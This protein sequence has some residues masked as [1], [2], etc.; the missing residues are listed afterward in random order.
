MRDPQI[1]DTFNAPNVGVKTLIYGAAGMGK[2]PLCATAPNPIILSVEDGLLSLRRQ[3]VPFILIRSYDDLKNARE[4]LA[5]NFGAR[6]QTICL[7]SVTEIADVCL[8]ESKVKNPKAFGAAYGDMADLII[9]EF[10]RFRY[11]PKHVVFTA[12]MGNWKDGLTG[13]MMWG[14]AFPGNKLDQ[15]VPYMFDEMWQLM[16][17]TDPTDGKDKP[18]LRTQPNNQ[19]QAK[20]RSGSLA[21]WEFSDLTY[22]FNKIMTGA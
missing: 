12:Q 1:Y 9:D 6:F 5:G 7:D 3:H 16:K 4:S 20:D 8:T 10:R 13:A 22:L 11:L 17:F 14:P 2:T 15:K 21:P 18:I 19:F